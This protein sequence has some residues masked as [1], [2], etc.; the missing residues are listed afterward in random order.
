MNTNYVFCSAICLALTLGNAAFSDNSSA[1]HHHAAKGDLADMQPGDNPSTTVHKQTQEEALAQDLELVANAKGWTIAEAAADFKAAEAIGAIAVRLAATR[2]D[3][4]V[5]SVLAEEPGG[6]PSLYVKGTGEKDVYDLVA[7]S[8]IEVNI[9][10]K[11]PYSFDELEQ[12]KLQVHSTLAEMG[13]ENIATS[14]D[15]QAGGKIHAAVSRQYGLPEQASQLRSTLPKSL[16]DDVSITVSDEPVAVD[17]FAYG[18]MAVR[19]DGVFECTAGWSVENGAGTTGVTT[20]G[21]CTGINQIEHPGIGLHAMTHQSEHRGIWGDIE[22]KTT[23]AIESAE[24]Y[25]T[26]ASIRDVTSIEP[27]AGISVGESICF[28]GRS[29]NSRDC[30][31]DVSATS[32]S[33]T[34]SGVFNDRLVRMNGNSAIGGD[35]GGGWSFNFRAYGSVKGICGGGS[36]FSVADLYDEAL[37]V[38]VRTQ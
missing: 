26:A 29:S 10:E 12:R 9:V 22:W 13:Y 32:V 23:V 21:H 31:F 20:A 35:S 2:P 19:D 33:C 24:F 3:L 36:V 14:F 11:Q 6:V 30:S 1:N 25:A 8:G 18:G 37:G 34:V 17:L 5:G 7:K 16:R 4:Y 15:F 38:T 27:R 28:Y